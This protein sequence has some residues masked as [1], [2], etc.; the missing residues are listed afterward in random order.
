MKHTHAKS[1]LYLVCLVLLVSAGCGTRGYQSTAAPGSVLGRTPDDG[2]SRKVV[3][4]RVVGKGV[5]PEKSLTPGEAA[6]MAERAAVADGYR[7]LVEKI[8]GVYVDAFMKAGYGSVNQEMIVTKARSWL[9]GVEIMEVRQTAHGI[10]EAE[11]QLDIYFARRDMIWWPSGL[12][13]GLYPVEDGV[14]YNSAFD[15]PPAAYNQPVHPG[16]VR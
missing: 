14:L 9:R 5:A 13:P 15:Y 3:A 8:S 16:W 6:I 12:G 7:L 4:F 10:T 2:A 1:A 11:L